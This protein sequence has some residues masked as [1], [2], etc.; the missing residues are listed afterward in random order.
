[1]CFTL[2]LYMIYIAV[3]VLSPSQVWL[4]VTPWTA[5]RQASLSLT[6]SR[7]LP[8]SFT[9]VMPSCHL[10]WC[11]PLLLPQSFIASMTFPMS[12]LFTSD[13]QNTGVSASASVLP[14]NIQGWFLLRLAGLI[15]SSQRWRSCIQSAKTRPGADCGSDHELLIAKFRLKLK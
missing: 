8:I 14:T 4:F 13:D 15:S 10:I 7:S 11:P 9:S 1:M 6:I 12:Q 2:I 5:A 3:V